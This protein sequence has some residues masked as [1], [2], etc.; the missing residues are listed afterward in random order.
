[1]KAFRPVFL[2]RGVQRGVLAFA[3][4]LAMGSGGASPS[5]TPKAAK[6]AALPGRVAL[7]GV[8][9]VAQL[10]NFCGPAALS[11]VFSYWGKTVP[12]KA[13]AQ[14]V[15]DRRQNATNGADLLLYAREEGFSAY[16]YLSSPRELKTQLAAGL[17]VLILHEMSLKDDRG[18]FSV[19][20]GYD[21]GKREFLVRDSN[22]EEVRSFS[23]E[24]FDALWSAFGRWSL[25]VCPK[26]KAVA[27]SPKVKENPVL[28]LDLGQAYLRRRKNQLARRHFVETLRLEP[29]NEEAL[30][31]LASLDESE[32]P[33]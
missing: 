33:I 2:P 11:G 12:Q 13:I 17:P 30:D 15:F 21:D 25:L 16:S 1:M 26:E 10:P 4:I 9:Y 27:L 3:L 8:P 20:V 14:Q 18:H 19:V 23:Y 22:Y 32:A 7:K 6:S 24:E 31:Q 28:H 5:A 29:R